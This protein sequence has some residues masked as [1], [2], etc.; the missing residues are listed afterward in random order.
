MMKSLLLVL[1]A[2]V[3]VCTAAPAENEPD[4]QV[5]AGFVVEKVAS[6]PLVERPIMAGFDDQGRLYVGDSS[7]VNLRFE[8]LIKAPPHRIVRLEDSDGDGVF[9]KS[10]VFAEGLTFPMGSLWHRGS[11][12]VCAPPSVWK[13]TDTDGDGKADRREEIVTKFGSNGNAADIHGPFLHPSGW[14]YWSDGRHGHQI[15]TSDGTTLSG[16]AARIFRSLP[17]GSRLEVVC[18]GGMDNPV[19]VAF[20]EEGEALATV[21]ILHSQPRRIDSII[22][23]VW[24]GVFPYHDCVKEFKRTG[25]LLPSMTDV[26]WVAPS[27]LM[28]LRGDALGKD[29]A[30]NFFSALFNV[31]KVQRHILERD[32][33]TFRS[34][35]E[36]FLV[37]THPD[38]HPTDVLEDA[39]GSLLVVDT[40][41]WFRIGCPTSRVDKPLVKGGIY[42]VRRKDAPKTADPRGLN[43]PLDT[44]L[45][46]MLDDARP[47]VRDRAIEEGAKRGAE[48][49]RE[50]L[51][52]PSARARR[53]AVWALTRIAGPEARAA[54]RPAL[55]DAE[56]SVRMAAVHS[57]G[58]Y[59]DRESVPRL[60][61]ILRDDVPHLAREAAT[62]LGRIGDKQAVPEL[63][64]SLREGRDRFLEHS[65][66]YALIE[67]GDRAGTLPYLEE[68]SPLARRAALIALDQM[69]GGGLTR[70]QV[71][72]CL[73]P[74]N[75]A[76]QKTALDIL[77]SRGWSK[78]IL[79]LLRAWLGE[80]KPRPELAGVLV[81]F[82][83]DPAVQ[84]LMASTLRAPGTP[85]DLRLALLEAMARAPIDR[86]P[87]TWAAE[88]RWSLDHADPRVVR[89]AVATLRAGG[90]AD[91]DEPLL[92]LARD[93][94]RPEELRVEAFAAA[95]PRTTKVDGVLFTF[96]MNCLAGDKPVMLRISAAH[97]IGSAGLSEA[98]LGSLTQAIATAGA[99]ELPK[100]LGA[101]ERST[102]GK[103][104][105][106]LIEALGKA[107][108]IESLSAEALRRTLKGYPDD[109]RKAAGPVVKRL[110]VDTEK[111]RER[112]AELEGVL[113]DGDAAHGREVFAG[114]KAGCTA[115][116]AV[117]GQG[118]RVGPDL[119]KIGTIRTGKDLLEAVV[120]PS[121]SFARG[122]EPW[123]VR[124]KEGA[125]Y[126]GLIVAEGVEA[127]TLLQGDRTEKRLPRAAV[128]AIQQSKTSVM[129]QGLDQQLT[130]KELR[131]LLAYLVS[132][133]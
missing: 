18:G 100:L 22:H 55:S 106:R 74:A 58:L 29:H 43:L 14:I 30:D 107:A 129:P 33:G 119:T 111:M 79:A 128:D 122:Y 5:P 113:S 103:V 26:G 36:D 42:R 44:P 99:L 49:V 10:V 115:C 6:S 121:A 56:P 82:A 91:F 108:A 50:A 48:Y 57:V 110:E 114:P 54:S 32:G 75:P 126:D 71:T 67:I 85:A 90:V 63:F 24:G 61:K 65:L 27:G 35:N 112:L 39:D 11:L 127:I 123:R 118:G 38:F 17:D 86:L 92:A 109:V 31:H 94:R 23:A 132:L 95:A 4:L 105:L 47:A 1:P 76:L 66:L 130:R 34:R 124:T 53:N 51:K 102:S 116:H 19:E 77:T 117:A 104:G 37:S 88:A 7:G 133:K 13:L 15:R 46:A 28:R 98:Q 81:G 68:A 72:P 60:L 97:A 96:L 12:Y 125:V 131:D 8:E 101:F 21:A 83:K 120:F 70:E 64:L 25:D 62:A 45:A 69:E 9:D 3:L 2:V 41:G 16:Q 89:Q 78:E 87:A 80:T 40:G 84:D 73:D 93:D 52:S 59:R 20:T